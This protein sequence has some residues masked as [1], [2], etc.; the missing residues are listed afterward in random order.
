[1]PKKKLLK[2]VT[3]AGFCTAIVLYLQ[4]LNSCTDA[5]IKADKA[6]KE[7]ENFQINTRHDNYKIYY[8]DLK[9]ELKP[10]NEIY[11]IVENTLVFGQTK[12]CQMKIDENEIK[13]FKN[14]TKLIPQISPS[15]QKYDLLDNCAYQNCYF[16]CNKSLADTAD[17]LIFHDIKSAN[18]DFKRKDSQVLIYWNDES[19]VWNQNVDL[20]NFNWTISYKK[21]SEVSYCAYGCYREKPTKITSEKFKSYL[22][23]EFVKRKNSSLWFISNCASDFR[24]RFSAG[25]S[26]KFPTTVYGNCKEVISSRYLNNITFVTSGCG[27]NSDCELEELKMNKFYLAFENSNCSSYITEKFW[28]SLHFGIIPIVIQPNKQSYEAVAPKNS[29]IHA[30]D[31]DFDLDRLADY[32]NKVSSNF[33]WYFKYLN[34]K[35]DYEVFFE[36]KILEQNRICE[37]CTKLNTFTSMEYYRRVSNFFNSGCK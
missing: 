9:R 4:N 18:L 36:P 10:N 33:E 37:L 21:E 23:Q 28:R 8:S 24:N 27:R 26:L 3:L 32:L 14:Y 22:K 6:S 15:Q 5:V 35:Q 20:L 7:E 19:R 31:F 12:F 1:M 29:F 16:S 25:L 17:A 30:S 11:L 2:N 13:S 34:W